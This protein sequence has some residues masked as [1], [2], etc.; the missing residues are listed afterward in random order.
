[1][2][3]TIANKIDLPKESL[4]FFNK[5]ISFF[6][7]LVIMDGADRRSTAKLHDTPR[8]HLERNPER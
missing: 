3:P 1:L 6:A 2:R 4:N 8:F 7:G 5:V